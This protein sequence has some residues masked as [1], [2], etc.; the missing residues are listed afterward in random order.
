ML[1]RIFVLIF[2]SFPAPKGGEEGKDIA[3]NNLLF[4]NTIL[5]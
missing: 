2:L 4:S 3:Y 1:Q 5:L